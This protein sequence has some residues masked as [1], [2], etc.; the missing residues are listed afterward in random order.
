VWELIIPGDL[1][2][3]VSD[4]NGKLVDIRLE[5]KA[6]ITGATMAGSVGF[7]PNNNCVYLANDNDQTLNVTGGKVGIGTATPSGNLEIEKD[8][9]GALNSGQG[10]IVL[11]T[12]G[13]AREEGKGPFINFRVPTTSSTSEDM[14]NIGAVCSDSTASSRKADLVFWTRDTTFSEKMRIDSSGNVGIGTTTPGTKLHVQGDN[15]LN[16]CI[17]DA[18]GTAPNYILDVRDDGTSKFRVDGAGNVGIGTTTPGA[19]IT[20]AS[21]VDSTFGNVTPSVSDCVISLTNQPTTEAKNNHASLQFNL[22]AG[23]LNHVASISLV[24]ES[25]TLRRGA[26]AF[27]TDNGTNRP[28]VMRIDSDGNVGIG[29]TDPQTKLHVETAETSTYSTTSLGANAHRL[30]RFRTKNNSQADG[31]FA[32]IGLISSGN[33]GTSNA[34]VALNCIQET[35]TST[36]SIFTIQQRKA[37]QSY[38]ETLRIGSDGIVHANNNIRSERHIYAGYDTTAT[39]AV[40]GVAA[41][42]LDTANGGASAHLHKWE[43]YANGTYGVLGLYDRTETAYR[44]AV[45]YDGNVGIGTTSPNHPLVVYKNGAQSVVQAY[46]KD[47]PGSGYGSYFQSV[48]AVGTTVRSA[49]IG[50]LRPSVGTNYA[51]VLFLHTRNGGGNYNWFDD[52]RNF[53]TSSDSSH[54]GGTGGTV[55]GTQTS[56]ERLKNIESSFDYGL[57]QVMQLQPIAY[58]FKD[59]EDE[60]R[61]LGFGAQTTQDIVPEVVYDTQE[62]VDG[63]DVDPEDEDKQIPRSE[64]TKLAMRYVELVPVLTKAIQEQQTIIDGLKSRIAVLEGGSPEPEKV[65][66]EEVVTEETVAEEAPVEEPQAESDSNIITKEDGKEYIR[67]GDKEYEVLGRNED[68]SLILDDDVTNNA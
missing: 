53:R 17:I 52:S 30:T 32:S 44:L 4:V 5:G 64:H 60:T 45:D 13:V 8:S 14:A 25:A 48:S 29:T 56:D 7:D 12:I 6:Q 38:H 49:T 55:I 26:L 41:Y 42:D 34:E 3:V 23:T 61:H 35:D 21:T 20:A 36:S 46:A 65:E 59:D 67:I 43:W 31:Q 37:D 11:D 63:Y 51:G 24:S 27:C 50:S 62:C 10:H 33:N 57:K 40:L 16:V 47:L 2:G 68:G 39:S 28:E 15:D 18:Q 66:P 22:N 58:K 54:V 1:L 19:K 9:Y